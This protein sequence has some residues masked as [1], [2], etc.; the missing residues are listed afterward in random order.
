MLFLCKQCPAVH[1]RQFVMQRLLQAD[2]VLLITHG[3]LLCDGFFRRTE[4][5]RSHMAVCYAM[6]FSY[7]HVQAVRHGQSEAGRCGVN[8]GIFPVA[9][10]GRIPVFYGKREIS[11]RGERTKNAQLKRKRK[12]HKSRVMRFFLLSA[13]SAFYFFIERR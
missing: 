1:A 11:M 9:R 10:V 4:F 3:S 6:I 12:T 8:S 5:C 2:S 7:G 13:Q